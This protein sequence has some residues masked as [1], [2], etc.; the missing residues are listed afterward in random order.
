MRLKQPI[1]LLT[2]QDVARELK[3]H[4]ETAYRYFRG[5]E[6][7]RFG[8]KGLAVRITREQFNSFLEDHFRVLKPRRA[9]HQRRA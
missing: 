7:V 2:F 5:R 4:I 6:V 9:V 1:E 3:V 8:K